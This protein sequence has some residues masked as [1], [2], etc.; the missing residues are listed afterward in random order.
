MTIFF[1]SNFLKMKTIFCIVS[2]LCRSVIIRHTIDTTGE[3]LQVVLR[4][5][6]RYNEVLFVTLSDIMSRSFLTHSN[7]SKFAAVQY[8]RKTLPVEFFKVKLSAWGCNLT[9]ART[10]S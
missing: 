9:N 8:H 4:D 2:C 6:T 3:V 1:D 10:L 7:V 5:T